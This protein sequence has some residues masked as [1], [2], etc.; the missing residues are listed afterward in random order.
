MTFLAVFVASLLAAF[1]L[2]VLAVLY[3][4]LS[5][6]NFPP[7]FFPVMGVLLAVGWGFA[8]KAHIE[9]YHENKVRL[10]AWSASQCVAPEV[11][12][13]S[14]FV[15]SGRAG[16]G[17]A[18][19]LEGG[20][21][22]T[23]RHVADAVSAEGRF[24]TRDNHTYKGL[25]FHRA[26][27]ATSPDLAFYDVSGLGAIPQLPLAKRG[28][29]AG[30]QLLIVGHPVGRDAFYGSVVNVL[31]EGTLFTAPAPPPQPLTQFYDALFSAYI[32]VVSPA[33]L[34]DTG[35]ENNALYTS[36]GDTGPGN[37]G[38]PVVNCAGEVVGVHFGGR[39]LYLFASE[40]VGVSVTLEGL[41][42]ELD[43]L[44]SAETELQNPIS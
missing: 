18:F 42:A 38:S 22:V 32:K 30:E 7:V 34:I 17:T 16:E 11:V 5:G 10:Q 3:R 28:A 24:I 13:R 6:R 25:L 20:V 8:L 44:P 29:L 19:A 2:L 40:Q 21:V 9:A 27:E 26:D 36:Q 39:S 12:A 23:N 35:A 43:K 33:N 14:V 31:G 15:A 41:K 1:A 4:T 37:S